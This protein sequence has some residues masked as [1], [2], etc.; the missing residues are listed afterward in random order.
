MT[1]AV[2]FDL[3]KTRSF[4]SENFSFVLGTFSLVCTSMKI[5]RE[6]LSLTEE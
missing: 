6:V 4:I 1:N 5:L 2:L 3:G